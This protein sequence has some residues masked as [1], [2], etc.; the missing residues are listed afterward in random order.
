MVNY[1]EKQKGAAFHL[2]KGKILIDR[3][4][5]QVRE[6]VLFNNDDHAEKISS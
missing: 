1:I 3:Q 6:M 5:M 2:K 4:G